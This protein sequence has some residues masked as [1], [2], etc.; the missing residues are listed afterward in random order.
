MASESFA[1]RRYSARSSR[2]ASRISRSSAIVSE[3][4]SATS[5]RSARGADGARRLL[6]RDREA[7]QPRHAGERIDH[8][9]V[10]ELVRVRPAA[11]LRDDAAVRLDAVAPAV[12][13]AHDAGHE[14]V[15]HLD[16]ALDGADA[17]PYAH[18][19]AV[20]DA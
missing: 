1:T 16:L 4:S 7:V 19:L 20:D 12:G 15:G 2:C 13:E 6:D 10:D 18:H 8:A 9:L 14:L 11:E 5:P 3:P 17:A